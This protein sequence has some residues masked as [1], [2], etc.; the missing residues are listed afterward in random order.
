MYPTKCGRTTVSNI[1]GLK[2]DRN[3]P[4][5]RVKSRKKWK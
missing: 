4:D 1:E 2:A 3:P 5:Y